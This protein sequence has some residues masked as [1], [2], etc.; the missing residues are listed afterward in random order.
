M[1]NNLSSRSLFLSTTGFEIFMRWAF[2]WEA[3]LTKKI[4]LWRI[5][6]VTSSLEKFPA[7]KKSTKGWFC[8]ESF[9]WKCKAFRNFHINKVQI[10]ERVCLLLCRWPSLLFTHIVHDDFILFLHLHGNKFSTKFFYLLKFKSWIFMMM[11]KQ[12]KLLEI[13]RWRKLC[14]MCWGN[15]W[16]VFQWKN[17]KLLFLTE[18]I[19]I[20]SWDLC[21][22]LM[23]QRIMS[24]INVSWIC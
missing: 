11:H 16:K 4:K 13:M 15:F 17:I 19:L 9:Y 6:R 20:F 21:I 18:I 22:I 3:S 7:S 10:Y 24:W 2:D 8:Q 12:R 5:F 1:S 14:I 23:H